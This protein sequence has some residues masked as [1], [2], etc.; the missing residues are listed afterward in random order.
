MAGGEVRFY[1]YNGRGDVVGQTDSSGAVIY[2]AAYEAFGNQ[3]VTSGSTP[4]RQRANTKEQDPTGLINEGFR[5][6]DPATGTFL[7]RDPLGFKA[8]PNMYT[9]VDQ[10]PWSKFD[11]EGLDINESNKHPGPPPPL[12]PSSKTSNNAPPTKQTTISSSRTASS[13]L[14]S[15]PPTASARRNVL[16]VTLP[17]GKEYMPMT[18]VKN[19]AQAKLFG[20]PVGSPIPISVPPGVNPQ[21]LVNAWRAAGALPT[22][23]LALNVAFGEFWMPGGSH[24]YKQQ[25]PKSKYDA[26]GN[27][28]F[29]ATGVAAGFTG[30][31]LQNEATNIQKVKQR[32]PLASNDPVNTMD[33]QSGI[34]AESRGGTLG[35]TTYP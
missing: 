8:G 18:V 30:A 13:I 23:A 25:S 34:R 16:E 21:A 1:M 2:Q 33:I 28:E 17:G 35:T 29:G 12:P 14:T 11:P 3:T 5:Y 19:A 27:F 6:R 7:T 22:G 20:L 31:H 24:D 4:D 9:Y 26:F 10:N 32:N 15:S